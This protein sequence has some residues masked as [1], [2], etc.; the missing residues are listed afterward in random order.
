MQHVLVVDQ[1]PSTW[2]LVRGALEGAGA[3]RVTGAAGGELALAVLDADRPDLMILD[4]IMRGIPGIELAARGVDFGIPVILMTGEAATDTR[5]DRL[6]WPH[7]R[8]PVRA[9]ELI[10]ECRAALANAHQNVRLVRRSLEILVS[11]T[12]ELSDLQQAMRDLR[13]RLS[14]TIETSQRRHYH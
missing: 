10:A 1:C 6:G 3:Y 4:L 12:A 7:L 13:A 11:R 8:K 2:L 14:Q 5:L 9:D